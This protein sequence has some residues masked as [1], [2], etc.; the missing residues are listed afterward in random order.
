[1]RGRLT[2]VRG[3]VQ[4]GRS[5]R[6]TLTVV[7]G[8]LGYVLVEH[9]RPTRGTRRELASEITRNEELVSMFRQTP[10]KLRHEA[11]RIRRVLLGAAARLCRNNAE[12]RITHQNPVCGVLNSKVGIA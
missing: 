4:F 1:M 10:H 11:S 2:L 12:I 6:I 9:T 8:M 5:G 3:E 7:F